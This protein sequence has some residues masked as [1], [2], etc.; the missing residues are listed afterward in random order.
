MLA[1]AKGTE[2]ITRTLAHSSATT[3]IGGGDSAATAKQTGYAD[4]MSHISSGGGT[5]MRLLE[6]TELPGIDI[7]DNSQKVSGIFSMM[8]ISK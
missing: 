3:I 6:G 1:F 4:Q 8:I 7:L 5:F 2:A